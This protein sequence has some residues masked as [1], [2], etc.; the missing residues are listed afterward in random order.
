MRIEFG[1]DASIFPKDII[2]V[3]HE[4]GRITIEFIIIGTTAAVATEF[5]ICTSDEFVVALEAF[6]FHELFFSK[7][8][9]KLREI[10]RKTIGGFFNLNNSDL[11]G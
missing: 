6:F 8:E 7:M 5:F 1:E 11:R 10:I 3:A 2:D 9:L 4:V